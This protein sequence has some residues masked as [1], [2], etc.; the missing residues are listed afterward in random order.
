MFRDVISCVKV[1]TNIWA[2]HAGFYVP[3]SKNI[4][5]ILKGNTSVSNWAEHVWEKQHCILQDNVKIRDTQMKWLDHKFKESILNLT[6]SNCNSQVYNEVTGIW[7][8][9]LC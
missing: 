6:S 5:G 2:K 7:I 4:G 8:Q 1:A 3:E 9:A